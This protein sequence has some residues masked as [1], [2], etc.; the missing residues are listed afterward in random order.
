MPTI[1][2]IIFSIFIS[3]DN[4]QLLLGKWYTELDNSTIEIN[5][6]K[7]GI[8]GI[9][10]KSDDKSHIGKLVIKEIKK[11]GSNKFTAEIYDPKIKKYFDATLSLIDTNTLQ[12]KVTCCLGFFSE[13][14]TW[15]RL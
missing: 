14:Y 3:I 1:L 6:S 11:Y 2:L 10:I 12:V 15:K 8:N 13:T 9:I 4:R 7:E 5:N